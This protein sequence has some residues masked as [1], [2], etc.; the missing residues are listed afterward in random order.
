MKERLIRCLKTTTTILIILTSC[1]MTFMGMIIML[2]PLIPILAITEGGGH[3]HSHGEVGII[4]RFS[5][6]L[7]YTFVGWMEKLLI[8]LT[9]YA[10]HVGK[11]VKAHDKHIMNPMQF[12]K[13]YTI[14][15][16]FVNRERWVVE[17]NPDKHAQEF[18]AWCQKNFKSIWNYLKSVQTELEKV[19]MQ[20]LLGRCKA[21]VEKRREMLVQS[22][23]AN[24]REMNENSER[25]EAAMLA[26]SALGTVMALVAG[27]MGILIRCAGI[28]V[29]CALFLVKYLACYVKHIVMVLR[30]QEERLK[31]PSAFWKECYRERKLISRKQA[32]QTEE[33]NEEQ[34]DLKKEQEA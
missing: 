3:I 20:E 5:K 32:A 16:E 28:G 30:K 23:R 14:R 26:G 17:K 8:C 27:V 10:K 2:I 15:E 12:W 1:V 18:L 21:S 6:T 9:G 25:G 24:G 19:T 22:L 31:T 7:I 33:E 13:A 11:V 34:D 4:F 29:G